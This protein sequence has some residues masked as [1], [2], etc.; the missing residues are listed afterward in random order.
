[1]SLT[2]VYTLQNAN[3]SGQGLPNIFPFVAQTEAEYAYDFRARANRLADITGRHA[4]LAPYRNDIVGRQIKVPDPS[5]VVDQD[6][7]AGIR[8]ELGYLQTDVPTAPIPTG[9]AVQFSILIVGGYSGLKPAANKLNT[10]SS[11]AAVLFDFGSIITTNGFALE[12]NNTSASTRVKSSTNVFT[13]PI[14]AATEKLFQILT[15]DGLIWTLHNK[16]SGTKVSKT[17]AELGIVA[18]LP[19]GGASNREIIGHAHP[20]STIFSRYPAMYQ[21]AKWSRVLS[22][23][24][25]DQQYERTRANFP[26]LML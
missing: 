24:E 7:G 9:G 23:A 8:I 14:K 22:Q 25:I 3:F 18:S 1:M 26:G 10:A 19:V 6:A 5:V 13:S 17:N 16:T 4:D 21:L 2:T 11:D 15:F 20:T 12:V